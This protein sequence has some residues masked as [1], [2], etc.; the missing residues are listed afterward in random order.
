MAVFNISEESRVR[1]IV[2][3]H[4]FS[5]HIVFSENVFSINEVMEVKYMKRL[6]LLMVLLNLVIVSSAQAYANEWIACASENEYCMVPGTKMVRYGA[7]DRWVLKSATERIYC[8]NNV[9][10]DPAR[11]MSKACYYQDNQRSQQSNP[12]HQ[13]DKGWRPPSG[14][15]EG[16]E[17]RQERWVRCA[18]E[19]GSCRFYGQKDIRYGAGNRWNYQSARNSISCSNDV[20]GDPAPGVGKACYYQDTQPQPSQQSDKGWRPPSGHNDG[21]QDRWVRCANE[22]GYCKFY[23]QKDIRYGAGDRWNYQSAR[24]SISCSNNV[25][26]DPAP[27]VGK[28]CYYQDAQQPDKGWGPPS[29]HNQGHEGRQDRWVRCANE[30]GSCR[31]YGQRNVRYGAG[32]RWNYQPARNSI[33]CSNNV[34]GDPAPGVGKACYYQE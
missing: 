2:L 4:L 7:G 28:A 3:T 5:H 22:G 14:H 23:G 8:S 20:F 34:F 33:S 6:M 24:N 18:N 15:N 31:F 21:R 19:G 29:G 12:V 13:P 26:G 25:F 11:G 9:F 27:G 30:G 16:H 32:N 10:G 17:G 1:R